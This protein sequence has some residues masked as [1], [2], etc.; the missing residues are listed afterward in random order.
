MVVIIFV[1][2]VRLTNG[3]HFKKDLPYSF[4]GA[5]HIIEIQGQDLVI[6]F[7]KN[8]RL[9]NG[10]HFK[11]SPPYSFFGALYFIF[12]AF[13]IFLCGELQENNRML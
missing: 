7:V 8:V 1:K 11:I 12:G 3:G 4:F 9:T 13:H 10:G 5:L 6:F 2:N